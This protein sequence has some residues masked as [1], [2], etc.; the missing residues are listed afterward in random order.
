MQYAG[1]TLT[2]TGL[3]SSVAGGRLAGSLVLDVA[4]GTP[5]YLFSGTTSDVDIGALASAGFSGVDAVRGRMSGHMVGVGDGPRVQLMGDVT[6]GSGSIRG[7]AFDRVHAIFWH[8]AG[9]AVDLDYLSGQVGGATIYSSGRIGPD[10]AL[11]LDV[12]ANDLSFADLGARAGLGDAPLDGR[13]ELM[14][15]ASGTAAGPAPLRTRAAIRK[16]ITAR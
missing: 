1:G 16:A 13:A 8:D 2:L 14:G 12:L 15:R 10:G 11:D 9:G 5:S 4:K 3:R 7:V 6:L